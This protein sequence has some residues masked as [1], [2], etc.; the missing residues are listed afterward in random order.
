MTTF[1]WSLAFW[2]ALRWPGALVT[3]FGAAAWVRRRWPVDPETF[4]R[5]G[6]H[7]LFWLP[8]IEDDWRPVDRQPHSTGISP[9][10]VGAVVTILFIT[11]VFLDRFMPPG[12][13]ISWARYDADF[14]R[15][16]LAPLVALIAARLSLYTVAVVNER[17][18][19]RTVEWVRIVLWSAF[20]GLLG[21][22]LFRWDIFASDVADMVLKV[23]L[24]V[25]LL[26]NCLLIGG[27]I[28]RLMARVRIPKE[29]SQ[30]LRTID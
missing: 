5:P 22:A 9:A 14:Q 25:F 13:D 12:M 4:A 27:W 30:R 17:W 6:V 2:A 16:L 21:W 20:V 26:V 19:S 11:P 7:W 28:R 10:I 15:W 8:D 18:R 24:F 1:E 29:Y 23:W 3:W